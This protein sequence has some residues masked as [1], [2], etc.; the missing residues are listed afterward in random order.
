MYI[1][2]KLWEKDIHTNNKEKNII[3]KELE[4]IENQIKEPEEK[5]K[6]NL[7]KKRTYQREVVDGSKKTTGNTKLSR[8]EKH[9]LNVERNPK[10]VYDLIYNDDTCINLYK[11]WYRKLNKDTSC[12]NDIDKTNSSLDDPCSWDN[13]IKDL[14]MKEKNN[15]KTT[16]KQ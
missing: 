3:I 11:K 4:T 12:I 10:H 13:F 6:E 14:K 7:E 5:L 8:D 1:L 9:C 2:N 16:I 15:N